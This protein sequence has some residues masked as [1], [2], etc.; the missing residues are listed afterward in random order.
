M[1]WIQTVGVSVSISVFYSEDMNTSMDS[2]KCILELVSVFV[3]NGN[4][5]ELDDNYID[6]Y[7]KMILWIQIRYIALWPEVFA[8]CCSQDNFSHLWW[9]SKNIE[10]PK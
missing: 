5:H 4:G 6:N 1:N 8:F 10:L 7:N 3:L 9:R 2:N